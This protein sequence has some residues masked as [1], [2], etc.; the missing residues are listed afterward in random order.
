MRAPNPSGCYVMIFE[1]AG[2]GE[3]NDVLNGPG[4]WASLDGL[5]ETNYPK[6]ANR[7]RSLRVGG[8]ANVTA[9]T[10]A[11]FRGR[12]ESY[13]PESELPALNPAL[14]GNIESLSIQC[15]SEATTAT[16]TP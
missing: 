2:F 13:E 8:A 3:A 7:I 11:R 12:S 5:S 9:F 1:E 4:R 14:S 15:L 10:D 6:W 16:A